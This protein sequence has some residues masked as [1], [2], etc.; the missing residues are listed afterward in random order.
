MAFERL[1]LADVPT[2]TSRV[3]VGENRLTAV[4]LCSPMCEPKLA[5]RRVCRHSENGFIDCVLSLGQIDVAICTG[6]SYSE[7]TRH[8]T[9]GYIGRP[10]IISMS[11]GWRAGV[12]KLW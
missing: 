8:L 4:I 5:K 9:D 7:V 1:P 6:T 2:G 12:P 11:S 10:T 3:A